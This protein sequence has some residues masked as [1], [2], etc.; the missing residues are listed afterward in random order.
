[1][2]ENISF[3]PIQPSQISSEIKDIDLLDLC[4]T[5]WSHRIGIMVIFFMGSLCSIVYALFQTPQYV[6][7]S[8]FLPVSHNSGPMGNLGGLAALAGFSLPSSSNN[9]DFEIVLA[10]RS[11]TENIV[12]ELNLLPVLFEGTKTPTREDS[13]PPP[14]SGWFKSLLSRLKGENTTDKPIDTKFIE[15]ILYANAASALQKIVSVSQKRGLY[16]IEITWK[17][18]HIAALIANEHIDELEHFLLKNQITTTKKSR[19]FI[20]SQLQKTEKYLTEA[21]DALKN[22]SKQYGIFRVE[23]Q[24][25]LLTQTIGRVK[26]EIALGEVEMEVLK[27]L[28]PPGSPQIELAQIRLDALRMR[29]KKLEKGDGSSDELR[30][31]YT[32]IPLKDL[33]ELGLSYNRLQRELTIQQEI[34]KMLRTQL[35]TTK[36]E[37]SKELNSIQ[38]I[39]RAIPAGFPSKPNKKLIIVLG[40]G[41]SLFFAVFLVFFLEFVKSIRKEN[42]KRKSQLTHDISER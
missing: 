40:G 29:L 30:E 23:D 28:N 7:T 4:D 13:T 20:E 15:Q 8:T 9:I 19:V 5:L 31:N 10:S 3:T 34:Y 17:D 1:M 12:R 37:E 42:Q 32:D 27:K 38:V 14:D 41:A 21:E 24:A 16:S 22:F 33:S 26:G 36:I 11:F 2:N 39:D 18:P 35:E 25:A 6:S